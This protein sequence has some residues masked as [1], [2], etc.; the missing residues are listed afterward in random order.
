MCSI[1]EAAAPEDPLHVLIISF[2]DEVWSR[3]QGNSEAH[4]NARYGNDNT[5]LAETDGLSVLQYHDNSNLPNGASVCYEQPLDSVDG[6]GSRKRDTEF[7]GSSRWHFSS[8]TV[9][10][11]GVAMQ[12]SRSS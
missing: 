6:H 11:L 1:N 2:I 10:E 8:N 4:K 12:K 7:Q 3:W 5:P 9:K